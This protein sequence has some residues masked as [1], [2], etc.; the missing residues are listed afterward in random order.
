M[1][2]EE[3]I[4]KIIEELESKVVTDGVEGWTSFNDKDWKKFKQEIKEMEEK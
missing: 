3:I 4:E 1:T 2:P